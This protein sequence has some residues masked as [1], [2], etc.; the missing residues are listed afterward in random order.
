MIF[1][2]ADLAF[3]IASNSHG[4]V[5]LALDVS[6]SYLK[7]VNLGDVIYAE[8]KEEHLG[9]RT[10]TYIMRVFRGSGEQVALLKGT[11]YRFDREF[12]AE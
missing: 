5:A 8:A 1:T 9:N 6:I 7:A 4:K 12:L 3:A 2:L 11:V 10:A